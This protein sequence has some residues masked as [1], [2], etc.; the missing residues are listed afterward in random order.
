MVWWMGV[1]ILLERGRQI[2]ALIPLDKFLYA[3]V[4]YLKSYVLF[5]FIVSFSFCF[6]SIELYCGLMIGFIIEY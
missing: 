6:W 1:C 4:V 3:S 2:S 5:L